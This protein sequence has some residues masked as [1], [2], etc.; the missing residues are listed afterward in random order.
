[1]LTPVPTE[2]CVLG[3]SKSFTHSRISSPRAVKIGS[4]L[5]SNS[6][7]ETEVQAIYPA[8]KQWSQDLDL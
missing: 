1:M 6:D 2:S 7:E 4:V 3:T 5:T 8:G